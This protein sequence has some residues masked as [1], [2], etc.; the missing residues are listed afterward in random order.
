MPRFPPPPIGMP[1]PDYDSGWFALP[2]YGTKVLT[3]NLGTVEV[4]GAIYRDDGGYGISLFQAYSNTAVTNLTTTQITVR[5]I[6]NWD[7]PARLLL[8]KLK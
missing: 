5:E 7:A 3:H 2:A 1:P 6:G 8:W 4:L